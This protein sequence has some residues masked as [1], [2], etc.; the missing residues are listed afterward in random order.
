MARFRNAGRARQARAAGSVDFWPRCPSVLSQKFAGIL[1]GPRRP[2][3]RCSS[4]PYL[5][6]WLVVAPWQAHRGLSDN[7]T[8]FWSRTLD[9][10]PIILTLSFGLYACEEGPGPRADPGPTPVDAP[11]SDEGVTPPLPDAGRVAAARTRA[12]VRFKGGERL[13]NDYAQWLGIEPEEVCTELGAYDCVQDVHTV[14]LGGVDP[15]VKGIFAPQP[16]T[17][18]TTPLAVER[19][20]LHACGVAAGRYGADLSEPGA[21][22]QLV[23]LLYRRALLRE[24]TGSETAHLE[25]LYASVSERSP[26]DLEAAWAKLTCFAVL[27]TLEAVFY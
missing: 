20:A 6:V 12:N 13:R 10:L 7:A 17:A 9:A 27:T 16:H 3:R 4:S 19:M 24:P 23:T 1:L 21:R 26:D 8:N 14:T 2:C 11:T 15:Y 18:V 25:A 5:R 22:A